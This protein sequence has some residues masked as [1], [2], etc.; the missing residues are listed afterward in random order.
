MDLFANELH[1]GTGTQKLPGIITISG[2][3]FGDLFFVRI[4][5][6]TF[7]HRPH[8]NDGV[9]YLAL[10]SYRLDFYITLPRLVESALSGYVIGVNKTRTF[11]RTVQ[12]SEPLRLLRGQRSNA[13]KNDLR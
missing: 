10:I 1:R 2:A 8:A 9:R 4:V 12:P 11:C 7:S 3:P 5:K 13:P 6:T